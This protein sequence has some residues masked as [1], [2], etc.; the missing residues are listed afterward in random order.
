MIFDPPSVHSPWPRASGV[1]LPRDSDGSASFQIVHAA[2]D[3][4]V[5]R[6]FYGIVGLIKAVEERVG[7]G[8]AFIEGQRQSAF[9]KV[10]NFGAHMGIVNLGWGFSRLLLGT[11]IALRI[12]SRRW[13]P[14]KGTLVVGW[15]LSRHLRAGLSMWRRFATGA[16]AL[17]TFVFAPRLFLKSG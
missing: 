10:G 13:R 5:P 16:L 15:S 8:R 2:G 3:F 4:F 9:Q 1:V 11:A 6:F 17:L 14:L 12:A 7:Q